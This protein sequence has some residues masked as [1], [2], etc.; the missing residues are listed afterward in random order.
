[1]AGNCI[2]STEEYEKE[3][4]LIV[5]LWEEGNSMNEISRKTKRARS[6][7]SDRLKKVGV[8]GDNKFYT[9]EKHTNHESNILTKREAI[10]TS[11]MTGMVSNSYWD[12]FPWDNIADSA[13][14]AADSLI[15]TLSNAGKR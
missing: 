9:K 8:F 15:S 14:R 7:I 10:A 1:M 5:T 3:T 6:T 12:E 4:K 2:S 13:V 11:I